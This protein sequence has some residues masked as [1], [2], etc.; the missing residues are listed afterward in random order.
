VNR[1]TFHVVDLEAEVV[2]DQQATVDQRAGLKRCKRN[3]ADA[4][5]DPARR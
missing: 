4:Y 5:G 3:A 1:D 2:N